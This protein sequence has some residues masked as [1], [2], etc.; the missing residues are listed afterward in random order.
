MSEHSLE[1]KMH[2]VDTVAAQG[3]A[4]RQGR[5]ETTRLF[6]SQKGSMQQDCGE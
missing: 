1:A 2:D 4:V 3:G 5:W 6:V